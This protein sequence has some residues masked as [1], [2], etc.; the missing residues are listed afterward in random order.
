MSNP[1][2]SPENLLLYSKASVNSIVNGFYKDKFT[3]EEAK[4]LAQDVVFKALL[5]A[6]R[7]D[8]D[9]GTYSTW[10]KTI[11]LNTV[12][13][14]L[15]SKAVRRKHLV[16]YDGWEARPDIVQWHESAPDAS[17]RERQAREQIRSKAYSD[18]DRTILRMREAGYDS[19][20]IAR[21]LSTTPGCIYVA[22]HRVK[23]RIDPAA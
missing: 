23:T 9:K 10:V 8:P 6:S 11:A 14:A 13:T 12:R 17:I 21:E 4:D 22:L 7:F 5:N 15:R 18:R 20:E 3:A 1:V 2:P 16:S 19:G